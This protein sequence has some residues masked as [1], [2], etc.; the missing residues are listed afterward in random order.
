MYP[1]NRARNPVSTSLLIAIWA[2]WETL[3]LLLYPVAYSDRTTPSAP[4]YI[5][6]HPNLWGNV[7]LFQ[8]NSR[9]VKNK[10]LT[11]IL[12]KVVKYDWEHIPIMW[13][14]T[15][16]CFSISSLSR[17]MT[18][19]SIGNFPRSHSSFS[20]HS[21]E[22]A[23]PGAFLVCKNAVHPWYPLLFVR[24]FSFLALS[25]VSAHAWVAK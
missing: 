3:K 24:F 21:L 20:A 22:T 5:C 8:Q 17:P 13:K 16:H 15:H 11:Q 4:S 18:L 1:S 6:S 12:A 25:L 14:Q 2:Y 9:W 19:P 10:L 23:Y 7:F